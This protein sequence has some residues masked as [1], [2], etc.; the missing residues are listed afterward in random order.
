MQMQAEFPAQYTQ[1]I[2]MTASLL[3]VS[4]NTIAVFVSSL[5]ELSG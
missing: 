4:W 5:T 3:A 1:S 2:V